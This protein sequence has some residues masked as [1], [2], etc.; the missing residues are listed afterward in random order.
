[1]KVEAIS[2]LLSAV[3]EPQPRC[4]G[5]THKKL[6]NQYRDSWGVTKYRFLDCDCSLPPLSVLKHVC[7]AAGSLQSLIGI[8]P[9]CGDP[10][11]LTASAYAQKCCQSLS[12]RSSM[13]RAES[14]SLGGNPCCF[15]MQFTISSS[16]H[17]MGSQRIRISVACCILKTCTQHTEGHENQQSAGCT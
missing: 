5:V 2:C 9:V 14:A 15:A 12:V 10:N 3:K 7:G 4:M 8:Y 11:G 1:M 6:Y 16:I 17:C 13:S